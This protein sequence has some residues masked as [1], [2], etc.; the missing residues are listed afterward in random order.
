MWSADTLLTLRFGSMWLFRFDKASKLFVYG[1]NKEK[2]LEI[3]ALRRLKM[4][5]QR[6][7]GAK[8]GEHVPGST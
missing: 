1:F 8:P 4:L 6:P 3:T 7:Y 5:F 2:L